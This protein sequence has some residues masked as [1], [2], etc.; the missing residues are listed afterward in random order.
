MAL[1]ILEGS[2]FCVCDDRGDFDGPTTGFFTEDTRFLSRWVLTI[3]GARPLVLSSGRVEYYSAAFYLRNPV[4]GGLGQDELS[5]ARERFV[6]EGMQDHF[7][8][9]NHAHRPLEFELAVEAGSDFADIFAVKDYDFA[10]GD[11]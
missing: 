4:A 3:N 2:T 9:R 6:G 7:V 11:P 8:L 1:T 10:L 5:I